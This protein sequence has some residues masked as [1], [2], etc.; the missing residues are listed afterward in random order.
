[1]RVAPPKIKA[2]EQPELPMAA[3]VAL[4]QDKIWLLDPKNKHQPRL[5]RPLIPGEELPY[6]AVPSTMVA[7]TRSGR[8][9]FV[10]N[11]QIL[12]IEN[13]AKDQTRKKRV[14]KPFPVSELNQELKVKRANK[15]VEPVVVVDV[16]QRKLAEH[17]R[18]AAQVAAKEL[19]R[20]QRRAAIQE[21]NP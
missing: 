2:S 12:T 3:Q 9:F 7:V 16:E 21:R 17:Q 15:P 19:I 6:Q 18:R 1:M 11:E 8:N 5:V 13:E 4:E 10:G 20:Q 14:H